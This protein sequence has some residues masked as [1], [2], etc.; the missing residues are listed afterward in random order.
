MTSRTRLT[1]LLISAPVIAFVV[2]GGFLGNAM[3]REETYSYLSVFNDVVRLVMNNYVEPVNSSHVMEGAMR[4]LA[5]ALDPDSAYLT[6]EE[7]KALQA[8]EK[9]PAGDVGLQLTRQYYLKVIAA[10]DGS[11]AARAGL[12]SGDFVRVIDNKPTREMS[13]FEGMRLLRGAPGS[14]VRLT[15]I[16]SNAADPHLVELTREEAKLPEI[17]GRLQGNGVGYVRVPAF[18]PKTPEQVRAKVAELRKQGARALLVDVRN[19]AAG[20]LADG[21]AVARLFVSSGTLALREM[22]DRP[23]EPIAAAPGDGAI[24]LPVVLMVNGGT[25]GAAE[26]FSAALSGNKRA[27]L[28]GERTAGRATQQ[29]LVPLPDGTAMLLSNTWFLSPSGDQIAEKGLAPTIE[30]EEPDVEFGAPAPTSDPILLKAID[31]VGNK[32]VG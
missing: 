24:A 26:M 17:T 25:A 8:G 1:V 6:R 14:K 30:V 5:E 19:S 31:R 18:G 32:T 21:I 9:P 12:R 7:A 11:P 28:V 10:L 13:V 29:K 4:G 20:E 22:R 15:I 16:R 2:I 23:R 27:E 3:A